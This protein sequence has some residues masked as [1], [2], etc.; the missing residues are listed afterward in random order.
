MKDF[1]QLAKVQNQPPQPH[2]STSTYPGPTQTSSGYTFQ[3][4]LGGYEANPA[5]QA[6]AFGQP[7]AQPAFQAPFNPPYPFPPPTPVDLPIY[8][9]Q[10]PRQRVFTVHDLPTRRGLGEAFIH[11]QNANRSTQLLSKRD[12]IELQ[13]LEAFL[14]VWDSYPP[15]PRPPEPPPCLRQSASPIPC[16]YKWM[17]RRLT[18]RVRLMKKTATQTRARVTSSDHCQAHRPAAT[19]NQPNPTSQES[20][21]PEPKG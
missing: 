20:R 6:A 17:E 11:V 15:P 19:Y 4:A 12:I 13:L 14:E 5:A 8:G 10:A 9:Q 7:T 3:A 2:P 16:C 21:P 18:D 1:P